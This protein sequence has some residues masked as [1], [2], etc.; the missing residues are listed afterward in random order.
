MDG[1][2]RNVFRELLIGL[3]VLLFSGTMVLAGSPGDLKPRVPLEH[4]AVMAQTCGC[5]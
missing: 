2:G 5:I 4:L 1:C 3:V